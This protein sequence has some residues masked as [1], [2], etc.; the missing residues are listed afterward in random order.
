MNKNDLILL[1]EIIRLK[2]N[3]N[4]AVPKRIESLIERLS[5][6]PLWRYRKGGEVD[7][8]SYVEWKDEDCV[9]YKKTM[10]I[11]VLELK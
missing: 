3:P 8:F 2:Q 6:H 4:L 1:Q 10:F 11:P 5:E 7:Q 9:G